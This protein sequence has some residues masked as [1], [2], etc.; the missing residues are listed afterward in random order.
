MQ[1]AELRLGDL[2]IVN[3]NAN[4]YRGNKGKIVIITD[5]WNH[6]NIG[7][8]LEGKDFKNTAYYYFDS[9]ELDKVD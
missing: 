5:K 9:S 1:L 2:V 3:N 7:V 4:C 8:K 6:H